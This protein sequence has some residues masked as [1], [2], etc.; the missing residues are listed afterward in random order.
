MYS[1]FHSPCN[2]RV[3]GPT[4]AHA[5]STGI[6]CIQKLQLWLFFAHAHTSRSSQNAR[7]VKSAAKV[8]VQLKN[9]WTRMRCSH[10]RNLKLRRF[11]L[12][13]FHSFTRKFAPTKI[14]RYTV[15][16]LGFWNLNKA[17]VSMGYTLYQQKGHSH[18]ASNL[19]TPSIQ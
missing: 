12:A 13:S 10:V 8:E 3:E 9:A 16:S 19:D 11:F 5:H 14:S 2:L 6:H 7:T 17:A 1:V 4:T 18:T 15:P